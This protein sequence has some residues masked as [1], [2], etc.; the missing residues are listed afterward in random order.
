MKKSI[1][2]IIKLLF[3]LSIIAGIATF[4]LKNAGILLQQKNDDDKKTDL[5]LI[6]AKIK[7]IKGK[8]DVNSNTDEYVGVKVSESDNESIKEFLRNIQ[9]L[10]SDF[11]KFYILSYQDFEK[12]GIVSELKDIEDNNYI[13]NYETAEVIYVKGVSVD[14]EIKYKLSEIVTKEEEKTWILY[15]RIEVDK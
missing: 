15:N 9:I 3:I 6:Q 11:E 8:S 1:F 2:K 13:I 4:L 14:N 5:L 7:L 10:D 12:M